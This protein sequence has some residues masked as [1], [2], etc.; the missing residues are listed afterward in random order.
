VPYN[1]VV[2]LAVLLTYTKNFSDFAGRVLTLLPFKIEY[3]PATSCS[4]AISSS[5]YLGHLSTGAAG[6]CCSG[7]SFAVPCCRSS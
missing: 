3:A 4:R 5:L 1:K 7:E 6:A 2:F